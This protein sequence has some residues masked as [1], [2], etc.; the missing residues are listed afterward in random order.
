MVLRLRAF[1]SNPEVR[2]I[3]TLLVTAPNISSACASEPLLLRHDHGSKGMRYIR[4]QHDRP[5]YRPLHQLH[6]K[7]RPMGGFKLGKMTLRSLFGKPET[8]R[9][10][11]EEPEHP[12]ALRGK[13]VFSSENCIYCGI[14]EKRCPTGAISVNR[15]F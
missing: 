15:P 5:Y 14:C 1:W 6:R 2:C 7:V 8:V 13:V 9:Y 4:C 11:F 12:A 3:T 10:P